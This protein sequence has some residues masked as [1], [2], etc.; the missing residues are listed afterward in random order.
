MGPFVIEAALRAADAR[1]HQAAALD[2]S[3][4]ARLLASSEFSERIG[5]VVGDLLEVALKGADND[6]GSV[7]GAE[8]ALWHAAELL[9]GDSVLAVEAVGH[10]ILSNACR[11]RGLRPPEPHPVLSAAAEESL[12]GSKIDD[13][14]WRKALL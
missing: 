3:F 5:L 1:T 8:G 10:R 4:G 7:P 6:A 13:I 11:V 2:P 14:D 12:R 9:V